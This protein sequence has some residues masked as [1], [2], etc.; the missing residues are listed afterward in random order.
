[1]S[2]R[3]RDRIGEAFLGLRRGR[4]VPAGFLGTVA[5]VALTACTPGGTAPEDGAAQD[6]PDADAEP[7]RAAAAADDGRGDVEV[8]LCIVSTCGADA[9]GNERDGLETELAAHPLVE[10]VTFMT[11]EEGLARLR[12]ELGDDASLPPDLSADRLPAAFRLTLVDGADASVIVDD[13]AQTPGVDEVV[14]QTEPRAPSRAVEAVRAALAEEAQGFVSI[15]LCA[16]DRCETAATA[17]QERALLAELE[18]HEL[19]GSVTFGSQADQYE[20]LVEQFGEAA[21]VDVDPA[22]VPAVFRIRLRDPDTTDA[23][24][25]AF[26]DR[27]GVFDVIDHAATYGGLGAPAPDHPSPGVLSDVS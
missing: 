12:A 5:V 10:T 17:E 21:T 19:V 2:A 24:I 7:E 20:Y 26:A 6:A 3:W 18:A 1:M 15:F 22:A 8:F 13:F 9:T 27:P 14:I 25:A 4:A 11:P 23:F 16:Q